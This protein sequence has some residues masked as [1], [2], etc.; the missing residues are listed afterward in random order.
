MRNAPIDPEFSSS[1][2]ARSHTENDNRPHKES[3]SFIITHLIFSF[4]TISLVDK[5]EVGSLYIWVERGGS[6]CAMT[7]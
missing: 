7:G 6:G 2:M 4:G 3:I 5:E 1:A